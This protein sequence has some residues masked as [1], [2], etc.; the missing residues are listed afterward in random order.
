MLPKFEVMRMIVIEQG[1]TA[2]AAL[3]PLDG[4]IDSMT[5]CGNFL[6]CRLVS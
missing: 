2:E 4:M 1:G 6:I 5:D 3:D